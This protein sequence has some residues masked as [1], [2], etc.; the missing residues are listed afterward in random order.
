MN[1]IYDV[2]YNNSN[3]TSYDIMRLTVSSCEKG[4]IYAVILKQQQMLAIE[5]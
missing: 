1:V 2:A 4:P 5:G 3:Y